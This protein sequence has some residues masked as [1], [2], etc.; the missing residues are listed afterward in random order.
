MKLL[1]GVPPC[2]QGPPQCFLAEALGHLRYPPWSPGPLRG[3]QNQKRTGTN[4]PGEATGPS[5]FPPP[6]LA[7]ATNS[8]QQLITVCNS[9]LVVVV[10]LCCGRGWPLAPAPGPSPIALLPAWATVPGR[11]CG[12]GGREGRR[13]VHFLGEMGARV[14]GV[15]NECLS[16]A[17]CL[18]SM[19]IIPLAFGLSKTENIR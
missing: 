17:S 4:A 9:L 8:N 14:G 13:G 12:R 5:P 3:R 11:L 7:P 1:S 18:R 2:Q 19:R 15:C 16:Q 10:R 6:K